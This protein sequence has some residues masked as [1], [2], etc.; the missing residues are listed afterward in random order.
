MKQ[1]HKE[2]DLIYVSINHFEKTYTVYG[3]LCDILPNRFIGDCPYNRVVPINMIRKL[4]DK[5]TGYEKTQ[6]V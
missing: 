6:Y 2:N 1:Y 5:I 4:V 3:G